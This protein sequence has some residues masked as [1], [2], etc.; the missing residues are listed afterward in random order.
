MDE[1]GKK[2]EKRVDVLPYRPGDEKNILSLFREAFGKEMAPEYWRWRFVENPVGEIMI[3]LAWD[4]DLLASHYPVSP[5]KISLFG[6]EYLT[7]LS[8]TT[9]THPAYRGQGL[10]SALADDLYGRMAKKEMVMAWGFPNSLIHRSRV[11]ELSWVD[12]YEVPTF[13]KDLADKRPVPEPSDAVRRLNGFD[14]G[15]DALW[16][17]VK[18]GHAVI[19]K[20]DKT[21]L[22]WRF[23]RNPVNDYTVF[24]CYEKETL[25]GYAV[26]KVFSDCVDLVDILCEDDDVGMEL[27]F[28]VVGWAGSKN[29]KKI[30]TWLNVNLPLHRE[31]EKYGFVNGGPITYLGGRLLLPVCDTKDIYD[32]RNWYIT[33]GD[34]DVY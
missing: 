26:S 30:N 3:N 2:P 25:R 27:V 34:S 29:A 17:R 7:G 23:S 20:R 32:Y 19:A 21:A 6:K 13:Q 5:V 18:G 11:R 22:D 4:G 28:A 24:G 12:I 31:L 33:M 15:F 10:F 14:E 1:K 8:L 16:E 9:M